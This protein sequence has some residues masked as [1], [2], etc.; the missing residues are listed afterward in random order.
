MW[1]KITKSSIQNILAVIVTV[2]SFILLHTFTFKEIPTGNKDV[3]LTLGGVV[4]GTCLGGVFG[5]F[6]G[7]SKTKDN[8]GNKQS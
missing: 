8:D 1:E 4:F 5:F 2:G 6:F 3:V 7:A